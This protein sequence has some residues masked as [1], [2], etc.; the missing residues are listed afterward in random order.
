[1]PRRQETLDM[2][3]NKKGSDWIRGDTF[4]HQ[5]SKALKQVVQKANAVSILGDFQNPTG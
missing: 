3:W 4:H 2:N 5:D 1:M